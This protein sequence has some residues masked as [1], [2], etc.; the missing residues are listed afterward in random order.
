MNDQRVRNDHFL[1]K[2]FSCLNYRSD[3]V[4]IFNMSND[5]LPDSTENSAI[6]DS[7]ITDD[8]TDEKQ[9]L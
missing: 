4:F 3:D 2:Y 5:L 9:E 8:A 1:F 7:D 6:A